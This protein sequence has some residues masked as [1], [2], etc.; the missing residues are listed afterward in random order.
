ME[1]DTTKI[2]V[3]KSFSVTDYQAAQVRSMPPS[4]LPPNMRA[5]WRA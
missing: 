1:L 2:P 3:A 4:P 5:R